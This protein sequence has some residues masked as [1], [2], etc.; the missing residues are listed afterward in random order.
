MVAGAGMWLMWAAAGGPPRVLSTL[1][2]A[3]AVVGTAGMVAGAG[4]GAVLGAGGSAGRGVR[5]WRAG[6][7]GNARAVEVGAGGFRVGCGIAQPAK[8]SDTVDKSRSKRII[9]GSQSPMFD[10]TKRVS[11]LLS[12]RG[13]LLF[14]IGYLPREAAISARRS[15]C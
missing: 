6:N 15:D 2:V 3:A 13:Y 12:T 4:V 5:V 10:A 7:E 9:A 11:R 8:A 1:T 14:T